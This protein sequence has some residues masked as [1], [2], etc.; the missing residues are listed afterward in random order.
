MYHIPAFLTQNPY[1]AGIQATPYD[2]DKSGSNVFHFK[3][4]I[5]LMNKME[6]G[7]TADENSNMPPRGFRSAVAVL[8]L[9]QKFSVSH[10]E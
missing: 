3:E 5:F 6:E 9:K 1:I 2:P 4:A 10:L 7:F 8:K